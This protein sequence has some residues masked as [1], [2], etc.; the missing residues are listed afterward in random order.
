V[1]RQLSD[2]DIA[3]IRTG[4]QSYVTRQETFKKTLKRVG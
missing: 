2:E 3:R 4:V 1:V